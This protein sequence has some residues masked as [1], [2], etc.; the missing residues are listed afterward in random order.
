MTTTDSSFVAQGPAKVGFY[1]K[2]LPRQAGLAFGALTVG[3]QAGVCGATDD[4]VSFLPPATRF[5]ANAGVLG[6][7]DNYYGVYGYAPGNPYPVY[8]TVTGGVYGH[9]QSGFG[10]R[11]WSD[12]VFGVY[13]GSANGYGVYSWS[14]NNSGVF[15]QAGYDAGPLIPN[16]TNIAGVIGSSDQQAGVIGTSNSLMGVYGFSTDNTG[17]LGIAGAAGPSIPHPVDTAGVVGNSDGQHGV[18]GAS[19]ALVGVYGYSETSY[20]VVGRTGNPASQAGYFAGDVTIT[21][22][23]TLNGM[24][25]AAVP[26]PDG[27]RRLLYCMESPEL[28]FEDFGT[29]KLK[30]GRTVVKLD[31]DFAKVIK[32]GYKVFLTP[33]GDCRGLFVHRKRATSFEV[34]ELMG[35]KSAIAFSYRIVGRRKDI[36]GHRRFA[37]IDTRLRLPV[38][39]ARPARTARRAKVPP[40]TPAGLRALATRREKQAE[41]EMS[42]R[43]RKRKRSAR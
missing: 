22:H 5:W 14:E 19:N 6:V 15:G 37:K 38:P 21:G 9:S 10:V 7:S 16:S 31:A 32:R 28:W 41:A 3:N 42:K 20:G 24:K 25:S 43:A 26:F 11:G 35:G 18:I 30:G 33:E 2:G 29:G 39:R 13:A 4:A 27:S 34:R 12:S 17:V 1:A 8:G 36:K 40:P 23:L